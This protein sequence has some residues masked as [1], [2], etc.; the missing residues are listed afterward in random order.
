MRALRKVRVEAVGHEAPTQAKVVIG[1]LQRRDTVGVEHSNVTFGSGGLR[2]GPPRS[3]LVLR[4]VDDVRSAKGQASLNLVGAPHD[5]NDGRAAHDLAHLYYGGTNTTGSAVHQY[6]F[7][8]R[9]GRLRPEIGEG[10]GVEGR[11]GH[12]GQRRSLGHTNV[13]GLVQELSLR[14]Q[15]ARAV[16]AKHG[17]PEDLTPTRKIAALGCL[18]DARKVKARHDGPADVL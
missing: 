9:Y 4:L 10:Q 6:G 7:H 18:H 3:A 5:R 2:L 17:E 13:L 14:H 11:A 12:G 16:G 8:P 15:N 1:R